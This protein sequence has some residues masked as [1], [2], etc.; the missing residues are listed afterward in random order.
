MI[1][2]RW[3][4]HGLP[5]IALRR[6]ERSGEWRMRTEHRLQDMARTNGTD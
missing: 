4:F 1:L 2:L 5:M 6:T 3:R